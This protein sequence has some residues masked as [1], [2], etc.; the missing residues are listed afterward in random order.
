MGLVSALKNVAGKVK[1]ATTGA[2]GAVK[3]TVTGIVGKSPILSKVVSSPIAQKA[4]SLG[5]KVVTV[6]VKANPYVK[7]ASVAIAIPSIYNAVKGIVKPKTSGTVTTSASIGGVKVS[8]TQSTNSKQTER[9]EEKKKSIVQKAISYVKE[10]PGKVAIGAGVVGAALYGAEQVAEKLGVRGGAGF[11]GKKPTKRKKK[12][13][14]SRYKKSRSY[15]KGK[16]KSSKTSKSSKKI[17]YTKRGQ[18][19]IMINGRARFISKKSAKT[20]KKRKGGYF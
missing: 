5:G 19:Y 4:A 12:S 9:P 10:N 17:K 16:K 2:L 15:K 3:T 6:A 20:R 1:T 13:K 8:T 14:T 11:I 7:A 18:P